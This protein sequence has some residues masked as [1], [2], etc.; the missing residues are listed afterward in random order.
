MNLLVGCVL[1]VGVVALAVH[2]PWYVTVVVVYLL[3]KDE[4]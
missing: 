2:M 1:G 4:L 3:F